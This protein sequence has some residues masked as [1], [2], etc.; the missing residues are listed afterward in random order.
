[1]SPPRAAAPF[2]R[3]PLVRLAGVRS[4]YDADG[5][6]GSAWADRVDLSAKSTGWG[7]EALAICLRAAQGTVEAAGGT[8]G[9]T[10]CYRSFSVSQRAHDR[11]KAGE[12]KHYA[13][14][15]GASLHNAGQAIDIDV[16]HLGG[17]DLAEAWDILIP[18][19]FTPII[20]TPDRK[21]SECWHFD[22]RG[23][24]QDF[25]AWAK[26]SIRRDAYSQLARVLTLDAGAW[27]TDAS[28]WDMART[29]V[30]YIQAQLHRIGVHVVGK[31]DGLAG[32]AT[33]RAV[34]AAFPE[35]AQVGDIND[36]AERVVMAECLNAYPTPLIR[37]H[38][39]HWRATHE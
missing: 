15:G 22:F 13:S 26:A 8:L 6:T 31:V 17:I 3:N 27:D 39:A 1:M 12:R 16:Y 25:Y 28:G 30:A 4:S 18:L 24:W 35:S 9:V 33:R 10:E 14:P 29:E 19:G 7:T 5:E 23:E 38:R 11:Y 32:P 34:S 21:R 2:V 37:Q 20:P 36:H